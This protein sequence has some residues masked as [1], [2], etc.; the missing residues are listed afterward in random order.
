MI[1][2]GYEKGRRDTCGGDSGGPLVYRKPGEEKWT[3]YGIA[4]WGKYN[5]YIRH[6]MVLLHGAS[7][8]CI[9]DTLWYC[10]MGQVHHVY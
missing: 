2:A 5:M 9:L 4:S 8:T 10:F 3:L 6:F 7:I 1:C